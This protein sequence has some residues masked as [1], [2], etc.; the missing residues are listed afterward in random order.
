M[1]NYAN[2]G[3]AGGFSRRAGSGPHQQ[4]PSEAICK[5]KS[6]TRRLLGSLPYLMDLDT[7]HRSRATVLQLVRRERG[8]NS[9]LIGSD[10]VRE[11]AGLKMKDC[12]PLRLVDGV[13]AVVSHRFHNQAVDFLGVRL[14]WVIGHDFRIVGTRDHEETRT[15][16]HE[17]NATVCAKDV[18]TLRI[19]AKLFQLAA[20]LAHL[21]R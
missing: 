6:S 1:S 15:R 12:N 7:R 9:F 21:V 14:A 17:E 18:D 2:R 16:D 10:L 5:W 13:R 4:K 8:D 3:V 20:I 19:G 11:C